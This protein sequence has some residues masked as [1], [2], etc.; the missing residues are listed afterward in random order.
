MGFF[1][2]SYSIYSR[3]AVY[4]GTLEILIVRGYRLQPVSSEGFS[5]LAQMRSRYPEPELPFTIQ[6]PRLTFGYFCLC[7]QLIL[8]ERSVERG[9]LPEPPPQLGCPKVFPRS[10]R[11]LKDCQWLERGRLI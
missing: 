3:T 10:A 8:A 2:R 11:R 7:I 1:P 5:Y 6:L 9:G 4:Y